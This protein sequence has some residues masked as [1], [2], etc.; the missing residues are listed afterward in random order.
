MDFMIEYLGEQQ[1][2]FLDYLSNMK[3]SKSDAIFTFK[4]LLNK[5]ENNDDIQ[6]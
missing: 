2:F 6:Y 1:F 4:Q 3:I 5:V